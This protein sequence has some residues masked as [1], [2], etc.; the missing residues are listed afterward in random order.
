MR[1]CLW[2]CA[3]TG[4]LA[5]WVVLADDAK[6]AA[7]DVQ[8]L[9][10]L[11]DGRP[12]LV[13][14]HVTIDGKPFRA[15]HQAAWDDY[16]AGLFAY[17]DADG[18]GVL[19]EAEASRMPPTLQLAEGA[20]LVN[21]AF[22][23]RVVDANGDGKVTRE[24]L[25]EYQRQYASG[26]F[27]VQS[28]GARVPSA[29]GLN[30]ALFSKLDTDKDGKLSKEE[31]AAAEA[32]LFKLDL[33]RDE[34]LTPQE[35]SPTAVAVANALGQP[36]TLP[37]MANPGRAPAPVVVAVTQADDRAALAAALLVRYR[38]SGGKLKREELG[39]DQATFNRLDA[40]RD[41]AL[42]AR[43]LEK[44]TDRPADVE[45][46]VRLGKLDAGKAALEVIAGKEQARLTPDG[47]LLLTAGATLVELRV[48]D[49]RPGVLPGSRQRV[50][51][52]FQ[53]AVPKKLG[54]LT[55]KDAV[56]N[57]FYPGQ[58][59]LLDRDG[60][61]KL[62]EKE[63]VSYLDEVQERQAK[64]VGS[65]PALLVS[66][67]GTGLFELLDRDRDGRLSLREVRAAPKLLERLGREGGLSKDDLPATYQVAIGLGQASFN[68]TGGAAFGLRG[69]PLLTLDRVRPEL[70]W[71]RK[72]DRNR[73]G[74]I[75]PREWLGTVE[76]FRKL[77]ADGDG[78][79]S[80][81]EAER[82]E[83]LFPRK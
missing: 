56:Q 39:L 77:D 46:T 31:L 69:L 71:F 9:V 58:F 22:N 21:V 37:G 7:E 82:A 34:L 83:T 38:P 81:E 12:V 72:M 70:V 35:L 42:D 26:A 80:P 23:F 49:G 68:R 67:K 48:N 36:G 43:E 1:R 62:T 64:V 59:T 24:E 20:G 17:L 63:L 13:R 4:L 11:A 44:Y 55:H 47:T 29:A 5:G 2:L 8:D 15:V 53:A 3:A 27:Q 79:I 76:D 16:V 33:D 6:P 30:E 10:I 74:D 40:D 60:D 73:D 52:S 28:G 45:L 78:L 66:E 32:V 19:S 41:G 57:Q 25:A 18:D 50:L 75:S 54:Y 61:G 51:D 14:L 65:T